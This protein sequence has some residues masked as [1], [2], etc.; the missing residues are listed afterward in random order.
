MLDDP[1]ILILL[2]V[3]QAAAILNAYAFVA[4]LPLAALFWSCREN[5]KATIGIAV[6]ILA[7]SFLF[8]IVLINRLNIN[9]YSLDVIVRKLAPI[10]STSILPIAMLTALCAIFWALRRYKNVMLIYGIVLFLF[11]TYVVVR[12]IRAVN[13]PP[14]VL[15]STPISSHTMP[16]LK[17][18]YSGITI[19]I[20]NK[21]QSAL[22]LKIG[23][24][25]KQGDITATVSYHDDVSFPCK[26]NIK[27][28]GHINLTCDVN[29]HSMNFQ[30]LIYSDGHIEGVEKF[31]DGSS[32][33]DV[34]T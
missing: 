14:A 22:Q 23:S 17:S 9:T 26:G 24:Q 8:V 19:E 28:G 13:P 2:A 30:G 31:A 16:K 7:L 3:L 33:K 1:F 25:N 6:L 15:A 5:I 29:H 21:Q 18:S 12:E 11:L 34:L 4:A 32:Y 10:P 20:N 27:L